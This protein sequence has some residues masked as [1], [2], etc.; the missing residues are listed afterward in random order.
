MYTFRTVLKDTCKGELLEINALNRLK[1]LSLKIPN[2]ECVFDES[3]L[4]QFL[5]QKL[6]RRIGCQCNLVKL[7][8]L[9][10][11]S[12]TYIKT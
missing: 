2:V 3:V 9:E 11:R 12:K 8:S 1:T 4:G 6:K 5:H 10:V 7:Y